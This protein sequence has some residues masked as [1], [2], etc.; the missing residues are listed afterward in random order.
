[1]DRVFARAD[2]V[3]EIEVLGERLVG[4][5]RIQI[6]NASDR[7]VFGGVLVVLGKSG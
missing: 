7:S 2:W 6:T 5:S 4:C 1:V 3:V